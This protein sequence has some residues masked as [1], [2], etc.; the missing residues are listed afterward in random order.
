M[1]LLS[2]GWKT[3]ILFISLYTLTNHTVTT[4]GKSRAGG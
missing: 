3:L 1:L 2:A 4:N